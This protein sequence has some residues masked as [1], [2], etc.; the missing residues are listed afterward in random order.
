MTLK[1]WKQLGTAAAATTAILALAWA[2]VS[3]GHEYLRLPERIVHVEKRVDGHDELFQQNQKI[4]DEL[5]GAA[6][7]GKAQDKARVAQ[8]RKL[9]REGKVKPGDC[10]DEIEP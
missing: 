2:G 8:C 6:L 4:L 5:K 3:A 10:V 7:V 9:L 1:D